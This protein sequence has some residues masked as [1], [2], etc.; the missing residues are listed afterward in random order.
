MDEEGIA[1]WEEALGPGVHVSDLVDPAF[2]AAQDAQIKEM[3]QASINHPSVLFFAFF[4][5]GESDSPRAC[6]G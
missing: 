4:N 5:E 6:P 3:V 1:V 2:L